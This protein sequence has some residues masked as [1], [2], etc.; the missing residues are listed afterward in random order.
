LVAGCSKHLVGPIGPAVDTPLLE[1]WM[2]GMVNNK[3]WYQC[4]QSLSTDNQ[5]I[6]QELCN[7]IDKQLKLTY[8][9]VNQFYRYHDDRTVYLTNFNCNFHNYVAPDLCIGYQYLNLGYI[10]ISPLVVSHAIHSS[11]KYGST[12]LGYVSFYS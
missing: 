5:C 11:F 4:S 2:H 6:D 7:L 3:G 8:A 1:R 12:L 10:L 9:L